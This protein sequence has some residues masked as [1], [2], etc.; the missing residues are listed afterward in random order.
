MN[1]IYNEKNNRFSRKMLKRD[2]G[3][4]MVILT[5]R[6]L[7]DFSDWQM[8][9]CFCTLTDCRDENTVFP[10]ICG[11]WGDLHKDQDWETLQ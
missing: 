5:N 8:P 6:S 10:L 9:S 4:R 7:W 11:C 3:A 2:I 1:K